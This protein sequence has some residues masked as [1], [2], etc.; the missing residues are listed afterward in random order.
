MFSNLEDKERV[1]EEGPYFFNNLGLFMRHWEEF[2]NPDKEKMLATPIWVRLFGL[3]IEFW[4]L[5]ILEGIGNSIGT[6][7]KVAETTRRVDYEHIPFCCRRCHEYGHIFKSCPLNANGEI[8]DL[9]KKEDARK[10]EAT[11]GEDDEGFK[12]VPRQRKPQKRPP[13]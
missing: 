7:V 12:E 13:N 10:E 6:S 3:P 9:R 4:D 11:S 8:V 5:E 1:F 2:Y